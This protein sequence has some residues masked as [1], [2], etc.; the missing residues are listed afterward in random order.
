MSTKK[1]ALG[2]GFLVGGELEATC[3]WLFVLQ[4]LKP[5]VARSGMLTSIDVLFRLA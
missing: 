5:M 4:R 1:F 2:G 3:Q